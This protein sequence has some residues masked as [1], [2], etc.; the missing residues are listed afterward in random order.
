MQGDI[1]YSVCTRAVH[2]WLRYAFRA[3]GSNFT[4]EELA[5]MARDAY[6]RQHGKCADT[7]VELPGPSVF[8]SG[9]PPLGMKVVRIDA[10]RPWSA[11]NLKWV[12][13]TPTEPKRGRS[14]QRIRA[15]IDFL[16]GCGYSVTPPPDASP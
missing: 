7:G 8:V 4:D 10:A 14:Q 2:Y 15:A 16:R 5:E 9:A 6:L 3:Q 13:N 11:A 1:F 12:Y